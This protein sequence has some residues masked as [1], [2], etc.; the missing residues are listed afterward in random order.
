VDDGEHVEDTKMSKSAT[1]RWR[2]HDRV[3]AKR[4]NGTQDV[5][6][7]RIDAHPFTP[8]LKFNKAL[9]F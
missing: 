5:H 7:G 1:H 2:S 9:F 6:V 8:D 4:N 3:I